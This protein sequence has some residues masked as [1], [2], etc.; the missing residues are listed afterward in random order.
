MEKTS[1]FNQ[2]FEGNAQYK[3]FCIDLL[4]RI[5]KMCGFNYTIKL[6]DDGKHGSY[7]NGKWNGMVG[8]LI[9]KVY[10]IRQS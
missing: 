1:N 9:D 10:W 4:A 3:G 7:K 2:T 6:V 8:E 5:S